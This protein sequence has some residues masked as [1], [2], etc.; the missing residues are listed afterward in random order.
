[1]DEA[2]KYCVLVKVWVWADDVKHAENIAET[3]INFYPAAGYAV[4]EV[5][6]DEEV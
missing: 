6:E 1:M 3:E 2:K 5:K 4:V